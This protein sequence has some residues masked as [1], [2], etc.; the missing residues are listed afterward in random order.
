MALNLTFGEVMI[1]SVVLMVATLLVAYGIAGWYE[2][3]AR[4]RR[5]EKMAAKKAARAAEKEQKA[6]A[7]SA[8]SA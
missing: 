3:R 1:L 8:N 7:K 4:R 5:E 2:R 6:D